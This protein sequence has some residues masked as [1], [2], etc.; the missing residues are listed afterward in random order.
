M[1]Y[2]II[3]NPGRV[4]I[5]R[6]RTESKYLKREVDSFKNV[7]RSVFPSYN[8]NAIYAS[9]KL[10]P[11]LFVVLMLS[12]CAGLSVQ[13]VV[14]GQTIS[15]RVDSE[16][17]RYYVGN[18]LAGERSDPVLDE[19]IDRVYQSA[20]GYLPN[21]DELKHLSDEFSVDFAALYFADQ[22]ARIPVN[23]RFRRD[24][25]QAYEYARKAFPEGR[26]KLPANYEVLVV[27]LYLYRRIWAV[28]A[29]FSG[30]R[31]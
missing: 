26:V 18:Y 23:R 14:G 22:I 13:G 19:R 20:N 24:F 11:L 7:L 12:A 27:P 16:V 29:D 4:V 10:V 1:S 31:A 17:A 15:T 3:Y 5:V 8:R 9:L 2:K 28:G 30:P 25:E 6:A 21:R